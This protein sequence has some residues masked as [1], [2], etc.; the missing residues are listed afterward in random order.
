[1][2]ISRFELKIFF[3]KWAKVFSLF[4]ARLPF[5]FWSH[6]QILAA[7][8]IDLF[9]PFSSLFLKPRSWSGD[10]LGGKH[11][12][13]RVACAQWSR[14]WTHAPCEQASKRSAWPGKQEGAFQVTP[15]SLM[16]EGVKKKKRG[17][18]LFKRHFRG[19]L[20]R[21][22]PTLGVKLAALEPNGAICTFICSKKKKQEKKVQSFCF[23]VFCETQMFPFVALM[24]RREKVGC[25]CRKVTH[26]R[27]S[28]GTRGNVQ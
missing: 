7:F 28:P 27:F 10:F 16:N 9:F 5:D 6:D 11:D 21:P 15:R 25:S 22:L 14:S 18:C 2:H 1:M 13:G 4:I 23:F 20:G 8:S 19:V 24:R 17:R 3:F 12:R 26:A